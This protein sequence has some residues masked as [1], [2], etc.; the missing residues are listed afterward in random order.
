MCQQIVDFRAVYHWNK[1]TSIWLL[2]SV[3]FLVYRGENSGSQTQEVM[4][5]VNFLKAQNAALEAQEKELDNQKAWLEEN[6]NLLNH[7][8]ITRSYLLMLP[9]FILKILILNI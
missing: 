5:Q 2:P 9:G 1:I 7:D 6:I 3:I 4:E 8:P